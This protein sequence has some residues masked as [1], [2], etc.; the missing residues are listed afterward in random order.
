MPTPVLG[1]AVLGPKI[2]NGFFSNLNGYFSALTMDRWLMRS[3]GR[4][5]GTLVEVLPAKVA[6]SRTQL[7]NAVASLNDSERKIMAR[8]IGTPLRRT[9]TRAELDALSVAIAKTTMKPEN[10]EIMNATPA[11]TRLRKDG[12]GL[13][14]TLDGQ[15]EAPEGPGERNW[16]RAVFTSALAE[17]NTGGQAMTMSD[18]QAL[19]WYPERRLYDAA[20]SDEDV[21]DGYEDDEAPDYAN[22][23]QALALKNG[24]APG[25]VT[26]AMDRAE[27]RGTVK[28][29]ALTEAEKQAMLQEFRAPPEQAVQLAFEV[30][31]DP[32]DA[33]LIAQW[34]QLSLKDRTAITKQAKDAVLGEVIDAIGAKVGKTVGATGGFAGL[35]NPN[36]ITEYKHTQVPIE[37]AR[38]LAAAIGLALDQDSVALVDPRAAYSAGLVRINL[39]VKADKHAGEILAAIQAVV[40]GIDGFTAR[41][42]NFD[43]LNFTDLS[44][45]EVNAKI[46]E[47]LEGLDIDAE[48]TTSFGETQSELVEKDSYEGH[49]TGLRPAAGPEI[50]GRVE[51]ARDRAREI[52]AQGIR[53]ASDRGLQPG[54]RPGAGRA[55]TARLED[56][57]RSPDRDGDGAGRDQGRSLAPLAGAPAVQGA[58]GPDP[59]LVE[60]AEKYAQANGITLRRQAEYAAVDPERAARI[61]D[62]YEA[63]PHAPN[64]PQVRAAYAD[65]IRQTRAQY[66]ALIGAGYRF[67]FFDGASDPYQGNPWNAMRE[68][69]K[70]HSMAV[71]G[72]YDGYGTEGVTD[73]AIA[74]NPMLA[75]TG[76]QWRDQAGDLKPV[77]ANDLFRAVHDAFG[78]G[79]EGAGF[80]AQ[81]EE[82]AWQAHVRLFTG[83]AVGA[84]TSETRGQ[85]SWLNYGPNGA[86]NLNAKVE[87]TVFAE[88]KTGLMPAWTWQEGIAGDE[89]QQ[90]PARR[91][92][93]PLV[94]MRKQLSVLESLKKCLG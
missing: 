46:N 39:T 27:Q 44:T 14:K 22:A 61:A 73:E 62:A 16:I 30:A 8:L 31:P 90:S 88:Q 59:R 3:W 57:Q 60:V 50:L 72:T 32:A 79:L 48:Y 78:H 17:L 11:G 7:A 51:R 43:V 37:Q 34:G 19:L 54:A 9:M 93:A 91:Q 40:P 24:I 13:A 52:V 4:M 81:G 70:R 49:I 67:T 36:L 68:L 74:S 29:A 26:A 69:R 28:G 85:N 1:S 23:A 53:G 66:D 92:D 33:G 84:I 71:Y 20:K 65:L 2:G 35:V 6:E 82:N 10:R 89:I 83:P 80:R 87:D 64:D 94:E 18:L 45:E 63:M 15:K 55:A 25:V 76:L 5:T 21:A 56:V 75:D 58:A 41:G 86:A 12:N 47:A 38:A 77:L 42:N